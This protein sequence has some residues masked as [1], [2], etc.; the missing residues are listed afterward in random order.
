MATLTRKQ[1][2]A[3]V[4]RLATFETPSEIQRWLKEE[5]GVEITLQGVCYYDPTTSAGARDLPEKLKEFFHQT[6]ESYLDEAARVPIADRRYRLLRLQRILDDPR[7]AKNPELV[8]KACE[9][10]AK[11]TG[12]AFT[13]RRELTGAN[14]A[15]IQVEAEW[16]L[17]KLSLAELEML[18]KLREAADAGGDPGGKGPA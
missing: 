8:M 1:Q 7:L 16:D 17:S 18:E 10:A 5:C 6:R 9:Q 13:N 11:D 12:G 15:A 2:L 4:A 14:G 3:V